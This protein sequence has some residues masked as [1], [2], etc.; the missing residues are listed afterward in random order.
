MA[1]AQHGSDDEIEVDEVVKNDEQVESEGE[2]EEE[3]EYEIE[4]ILDAKHGAFTGVRV[5]YALLSLYL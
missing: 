5:S 4:K 1:K 3:E 2:E